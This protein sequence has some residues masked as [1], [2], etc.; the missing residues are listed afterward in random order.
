MEKEY[1]RFGQKDLAHYKGLF[2]R[3]DIQQDAVH[4]VLSDIHDVWDW[5]DYGAGYVLVFL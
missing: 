1:G 4:A 3:K 2:V 5:A